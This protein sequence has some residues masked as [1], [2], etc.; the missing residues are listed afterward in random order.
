MLSMRGFIP[1]C[2]IIQPEFS[3]YF[4]EIFFFYGLSLL[5]L[6]WMKKWKAKARDNQF[7][8][9]TIVK[10]DS[11]FNYAFRGDIVTDAGASSAAKRA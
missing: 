2:I 9:K 8:Y 6:K 4:K 11:K 10:A 1:V 5:T 7:I 3:L